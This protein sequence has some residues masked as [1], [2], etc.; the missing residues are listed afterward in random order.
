MMLRQLVTLSSPW[1][2]FS[3]SPAAMTEA[4]GQHK[5]ATKGEKLPQP[6]LQRKKSRCG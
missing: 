4:T 3:H 5:L 6:K 2:R 1:R